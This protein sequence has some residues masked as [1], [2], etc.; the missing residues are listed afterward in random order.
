MFDKER[1]V[2]TALSQRR[3]VQID[4]IDA[5]EKVFA[6]RVFPDHRPQVCIGGTYHA[7]ISSACVAVAQHLVGLVLQH[8]QQLH[9]TGQ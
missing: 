2:F 7:D 5:V 3:Q 8:T 9:L 6:E 4:Q 1:N